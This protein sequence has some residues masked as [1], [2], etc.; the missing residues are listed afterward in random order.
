M[1]ITTNNSSLFSD[2]Q[3]TFL[4]KKKPTKKKRAVSN[5]EV[6]SVAQKYRQSLNPP[7]PLPPLYYHPPPLGPGPGPSNQHSLTRQT[8]PGRCGPPLARQQRAPTYMTSLSIRGE[9]YSRRGDA[10]GAISP[11]PDCSPLASLAR[12]HTYAAAWPDRLW[13]L[14]LPAPAAVAAAAS[15]SRLCVLSC[16]S[17]R[18]FS[19]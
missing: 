14:L 3:Q 16:I 13:V 8:Q 7:H 6:G 9:N 19:T 1:Q 5:A 12:A 4:E 17:L 18:L 2:Q 15:G 11:R 10:D